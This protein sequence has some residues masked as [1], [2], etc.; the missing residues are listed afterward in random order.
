MVFRPFKLVHPAH[1]Y[2]DP[3]I[4]F[5]IPAVKSEEGVKKQTR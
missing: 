5:S 4:G 2:L 3:P 1:K